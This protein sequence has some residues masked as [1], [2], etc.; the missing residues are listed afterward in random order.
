MTWTTLIHNDWFQLIAILIVALIA[1]K[2]VKTILVSGLRS[3]TKK[4]E[5]DFDDVI[6]DIISRPLYLTTFILGT[7]ISLLSL[8]IV[9]G[10][11]ALANKL[12]FVAYVLL[13]TYVLA[14]IFSKLFNS[15]FKK[16]RRLET[17]PKLVSR[18]INIAVYL[19][20]LIIIM[21]YF[22]IE[23]SPL[24]ATLGIGGLAVGL[25][26][27][28]TLSNFF[29]GIQ[30]ISDEPVKVG[31]FV[32]IGTDIKGTVS[33]IGWRSTRIKTMGNNV[34][35]IPNS[36]VANS[37]ITNNS[38]GDPQQSL[39]VQVGISYGEDLSKVE[40]VTNEV[41]KKI[42]EYA[43]GAKKGYEPFIRFHTFGDS[44]INFTVIMRVED[45]VSQYL[46]KHEFIKALKARY[47]KEGIEI[48]WP[49]RKIV[50]E[51]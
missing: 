16:K 45:Y 15:W 2:I 17:A 47:D 34:V 7:H 48:S 35:T 33:D 51:K 41:A 32:E 36:T 40:M 27:Q 18:L 31:D 25:A 38:I 42:Q 23:I 10:Y 39:L 13:I 30:I 43:P 9:N 8:N 3:A 5:S 12:F 24:I 49:V 1:A 44:N 29:S 11:H 50:N 46:V 4:T 37:I 22:N 26:L 20:A 28:D 19:V 21:E 6:I 14:R